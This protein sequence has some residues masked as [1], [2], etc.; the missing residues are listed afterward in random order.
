MSPPTASVFVGAAVV[1]TGLQ[2][3]VPIVIGGPCVEFRLLRGALRL[4]HMR[5][6]SARKLA[7][8]TASGASASAAIC[9]GPSMNE[10][11]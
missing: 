6:S 8:S 4:D 5:L 11:A 1:W 9:S 10:I 3:A 7:C 2:V